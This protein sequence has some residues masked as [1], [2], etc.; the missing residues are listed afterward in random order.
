MRCRSLPVG[1]T[2]VIANGTNFVLCVAT[3]PNANRSSTSGKSVQA[4]LALTG[5]V[6]AH[7]TVT[8]TDVVFTQTVPA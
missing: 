1:A 2:T 4:R 8:A 7:W 3:R 6:G 5:I